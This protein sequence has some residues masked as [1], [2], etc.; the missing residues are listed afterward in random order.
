MNSLFRTHPCVG[1]YFCFV[2]TKERHHTAKG[3]VMTFN[4]KKGFNSALAAILISTATF[5]TAPTASAGERYHRNH[6]GGMYEGL[7]IG[8]GVALIATAI[9]NQSKPSRCR[10]QAY[11]KKDAVTFCTRK[12]GKPAK[13]RGKPRRWICS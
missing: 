12:L 11:A 7:A 13:C 6:G 3:N 2:E 5:A 1:A 9:A 10:S 8:L 4:M